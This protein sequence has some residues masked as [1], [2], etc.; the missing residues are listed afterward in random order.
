MSR[1]LDL[2]SPEETEL[3]G[4]APTFTVSGFVAAINQTLSGAYPDVEVE[5]EVSSFNINQ[6]KFVFFNLKDETA[7][8]SCFL[9]AFNLR[10]P[11]EDG[12]KVKVKAIP[13][14]TD[15]GRFSLSVKK[16][17][18]SGEGTL[19]RAYELLKAKLNEEGLFDPARKR[20]L[21]QFPEQVGVIASETSAGYS[22]FQKIADELWGGVEFRLAHVQVQGESA[23]D[24][25]ITALEYMNEMPS[26]PDV[27]VLI[28]GGGSLEDLAAFNDEQVARAVATSRVP[29]LVGIGHEVDV[30]L[31][32]L[33]ADVRASTPSNA[34]QLLLPDRA[35][36]SNILKRWA[37][38]ILSSMNRLVEGRRREF[39][40]A[41]NEAMSSLLADTQAKLD[42]LVRT[43]RGYDP[44]QA[45]LRGYAIA[46]SEG[47]ILKSG[48]GLK[49]ESVVVL[50]LSDV[51]LD[52]E[53]KNVSKKQ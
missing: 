19:K 34:A 1:N 6:G 50:E 49:I 10:V 13:K 11:L 46:R 37:A 31:A 45:L 48:K 26:L 43:L 9:M 28:R 4:S 5:G 33:A 36:Y 7:S 32:G 21:P 44:K 2:F 30:T 42:S 16:I 51:M 3:P 25:I 17:E 38:Q 18:L 8:V 39:I 47:S 53:V 24:Q 35:E 29:T 41:M 22:D 15:K 20:L 40:Q 23:P 14:L 12:M 52:T 27:V